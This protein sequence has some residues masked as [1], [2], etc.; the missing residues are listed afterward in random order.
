[1]WLRLFKNA[2]LASLLGGLLACE[3]TEGPSTPS[4]MPVESVSVTSVEPVIPKRPLVTLYF[5]YGCPHCF[6]F[7][8]YFQAWLEEWGD[9]ITFSAVPIALKPSWID[10]AR[11][12]Y[13]AQQL[14]VL[15][16]FHPALYDALHVE[17]R[18]LNSV[19]ALAEFAGSLGIDAE[20][21]QAAMLSS[22]T[23][24]SIRRDNAAIKRLAITTTPTLVID[25][26]HRLSLRSHDGYDGLL[27]L[28]EDILEQKLAE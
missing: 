27:N 1:M 28:A 15:T 4:A 24:V 12:F 7:R 16:R 10:H 22:A 11:A 23:T 20:A 5:W 2:L 8:H 26:R 21:F 9:K 25:D 18:K 3:A 19:A 6:E 13:A 17:K 14:D